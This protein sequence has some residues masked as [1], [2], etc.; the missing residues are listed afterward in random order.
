[1]PAEGRIP[2]TKDGSRHEGRGSIYTVLFYGYG[3]HG[4]LR[5]DEE[6]IVQKSSELTRNESM[7]PPW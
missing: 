5:L 6:E 1:M 7:T 3:R 2:F 4:A